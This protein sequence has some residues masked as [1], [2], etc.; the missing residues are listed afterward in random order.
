MNNLILLFAR[1]LLAHM[2]LLS[3]IQKIG[4]YAGTAG[5]MVSQGVPAFLLTPVI[6][7]EVIGALCIIAGFGTRIATYALAAFCIV[8]AII[9]HGDFS[10]QGQTVQFM[11]NFTIAGG[12]L[13]LGVF[14]P[15]NWKVGGKF[16][17]KR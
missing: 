2:F 6:V 11:K 8:A 10:V 15:G 16:S 14:G 12:L 7:L 9:F 1:F 3:G 13:V 5:Y 4:G 17:W